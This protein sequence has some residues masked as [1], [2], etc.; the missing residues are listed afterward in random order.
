MN[1]KDFAIATRGYFGYREYTGTGW[2]THSPRCRSRWSEA[3]LN[4]YR[5]HGSKEDLPLTAKKHEKYTDG[6]LDRL[7]DVAYE[8]IR[9]ELLRCGEKA[10]GGR[11]TEHQI[12]VQL[13]LSRT[14]VREAIQRL[15]LEGW[16]EERPGSGFTP[17]PSSMRDVLDIFELRLLLEPLAAMLAAQDPT[18]MLADP[19][20]PGAPGSGLSFHLQ[21]ASACGISTLE[22]AILRIS[23]TCVLSA[24]GGGSTDFGSDHA[25]IAAAINRGDA[26][27]SGEAMSEHLLRVRQDRVGGLSG[28]IDIGV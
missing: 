10:F 24:S 17:R 25:R 21:V 9:A 13:S 7:S 1:C 4:C 14:P 23:R 6:T 20:P 15:H 19:P 28:T 18:V 11:F 3:G 26:Q 8:Q 27:D 22:D 12:A 5:W 2:Y 16:L